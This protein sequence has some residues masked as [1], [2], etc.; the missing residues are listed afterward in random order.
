VLA[1]EAEQS[2]TSGGYSNN[3]GALRSLGLIDYPVPG[4]VVATALLFPGERNRSEEH[5]ARL[6]ASQG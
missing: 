4:Q 6:L 5:D 1:E 2:A 3:L